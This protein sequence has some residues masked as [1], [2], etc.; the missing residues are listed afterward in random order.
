MTATRVAVC[1][2]TYDSAPD[3]SACFEAVAAQDHRP[4][5]LVVVDCASADDSVAVA[6]RIEVPGVPKRVVALADNLGFTGGMNAALAATDAST[7]PRG[8]AVFSG[9]RRSDRW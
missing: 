6:R 9:L 3:L 2:V 8:T 5:E 1:I 4:L 7:T